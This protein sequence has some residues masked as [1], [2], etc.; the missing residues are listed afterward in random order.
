M[1]AMLFISVVII[2]L[3]Q[4]VKMAL[5]ERVY[6]FVTIL[7]ALAIGLLV[8]IFDTALG[9]EDITIAEGIVAALGAIGISTVASKAGGG[10]KG[11]A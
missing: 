7:I 4:M 1:E 2:A 11:D 10:A 3:T 5:P 9:I 8:A 6:G